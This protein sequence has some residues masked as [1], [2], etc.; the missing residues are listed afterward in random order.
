MDRISEIVKLLE[1]GGVILFPTD[2]IWGLGCDACSEKAVAKINTIKGRPEG[3]P[4]VV[5][6][7][8]IAMVSQYVGRIH[9]KIETLIQYHQRPLTVVY[10]HARNIAPSVKAEDGSLAIRIPMDSFCLELIKAFGRPIVSTS[11]NLSGQPFPG[12]FKGINPKIIE[13]VDYTF[14]YRRNETRENVPST[15]VRLTENEELDFIRE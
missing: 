10:N 4:Y 15:I 11:A 8:S 6:C 3:K 13:A 9:P 12:N 14:L 1:E 7:D 2:T 5:L